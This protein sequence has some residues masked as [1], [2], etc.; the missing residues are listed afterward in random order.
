MKVLIL[1]PVKFWVSNL[2]WITKLRWC[3]SFSGPSLPLG[4]CRSSRTGGFAIGRRTPPSFLLGETWRPWYWEAGITK[5]S[6]FFVISLCRHTV[7]L[8]LMFTKFVG[9]PDGFVCISPLNV[10]ETW[11]WMLCNFSLLLPTW[12]VS[13]YPTDLLLWR[14]PQGSVNP[15]CSYVEFVNSHHKLWLY[16]DIV[17]TKSLVF[18]YSGS[19]CVWIHLCTHVLTEFFLCIT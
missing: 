7:N 9:L 10:H 1:S 5:R 8:C 6:K 18:V 4:D 16:C 15:L 19:S 2:N 14:E 17:L 11:I 13:V 3:A 12:R